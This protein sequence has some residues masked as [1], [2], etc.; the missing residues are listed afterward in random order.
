MS[1]IGCSELY[2]L[3]QPQLSVHK[4]TPNPVE[5]IMDSK[6][7]Y[8]E[9]K[10]ALVTGSSRGIGR[11]IA[12]KLAERGANVAVNYI[13]NEDA[14]KTTLAEIRKRGADGFIVKAD[15]SQPE[16]VAEMIKATQKNFDGLDILVSNA[17][18]KFIEK[19]VPPLQTTLDQFGEAFREHSRAYL[20]CVQQ[21]AGVMKNGGRVIAISYWPGSHSGGFLPYFSTGTN[22]AAMEAMSRYFAVALAPRN[23]TVNTVCP[24]ITEDSVFNALPAEAQEAIRDWAKQGWNPRRRMGTTAEIGGAVAALCSEDA[25]WITGQTIAA[26]GGV[27]LTSTEV[28]V[29]FQIPPA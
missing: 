22:K 24:G 13:N 9:G 2:A 15:I 3:G 23:I 12:L 8:L 29:F 6:H 7:R 14:A 18:G 27:S 4:Q 11:G 19:L 1:Y 20:N 5:H 28:P 21:A 26:D 10:F 16:D 25:G 17:I